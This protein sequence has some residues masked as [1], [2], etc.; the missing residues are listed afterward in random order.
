MDLP[1]ATRAA[2]GEAWDRAQEKQERLLEDLK[3]EVKADIKDVGVLRKELHITIPAKIIA[4]HLEHNYDELRH[5]ALVPGFRKGHAPRRLIE[6]RFG[7]EVR[8]SLTSSIVGQAYF[9]V[10]E[11][12]ELD[13]LGDPLFRIET[14]ASVKLMDIGEAL[15]HFKLPEDAD[16]TYV[17]EIEL[18]P[19]FELPELKGIEIKA[20]EIEVTDEMVAEQMLQ[21]RKNRGRYEPL[22]EA[23]EKDDQLITDVILTVDGQEVKREENVSVGVRATRLD[24]IPLLTLDEVLVGV[25]AGESRTADCT[26][27]DD[28]ERAD[29][30]GK[31][32]QFEFKVHELKRLAPEPLASF[33]EAWGFEH[34]EEARAHFREELSAERDQL[35]ERAKKAQVE[36]YLLVHTKLDLPQDFSARQTDRAVVRKVVE[37]QQRGVPASDIEAKIDE[38]RTSA[39]EQVAHELKLGFVLDKVAD[40]FDVDVTDEEVNTEIARIAQLYNR[41]FDRI[42]DDLQSRGLLNQLVEQIRHGK[43]V[44]LLLEDAKIVKVEAEQKP[45]KATKKVTEKAPKKSTKKATRKSE[46]E[47]SE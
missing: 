44:A 11:N 47:A 40:Q 12:E 22:T 27:P 24:G 37:L 33:L 7:A 21:R 3:K 16:F 29:L 14:D 9:A 1:G 30:R 4:D 36:D 17:C 46:P 19:T 10:T 8:E 28:Y 15:Q 31:R 32:G 43:C 13:V 38:L 18:K 35:L 5:D 20:P 6:K 34:E 45:K 2:D 42:R 39:K 41:R 23:A 26:I 25:K